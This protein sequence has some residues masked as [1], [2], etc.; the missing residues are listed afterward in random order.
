MSQQ[1][2]KIKD[3]IIGGENI[4]LKD[5]ITTSLTS[6]STDEEIASAK[7]VFEADKLKEDVGVAATLDATVLSDAKSYADGLVVAVI[8]DKGNYNPNTNT[9]QYPTTTGIKEG[10][11]WLIS[12]LGAGVTCLIGTKTVQDGDTIR[13]LSDTP[14]QTE[15]NWAIAESNLGFT[16]ENSANKATTITGNETSTTKFPAI[17]AILDWGIGAFNTKLI[18]VASVSVLTTGWTLVSGIYEYSI[19][20]A[21][22]LSTSIVD[23]IPENVDSATVLLAEL[24]P[25]TTSSVGAVKIYANYVPLSAFTVTLNIY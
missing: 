23:I 4:L 10:W 9:N 15:A 17:K 25:K 20:N 5:V 12:G 18:Q 19:S 1:I 8:K 22:I 11:M 13:A 3:D 6:S 21:N 7:T 2:I 16:P 14:G 24:Y